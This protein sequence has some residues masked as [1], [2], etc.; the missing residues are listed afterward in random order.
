MIRM[1]ALLMMA[2]LDGFEGVLSI[3]GWFYLFSRSEISFCRYSQATATID[4]NQQAVHTWQ[5]LMIHP[6]DMIEPEWLEWYQM[7][8]LQRLE[9]S[10]RLR[11]DYLAMGGSLEPDPDP[12]SPFWSREEI[13]AFAKVHAKARERAFKLNKP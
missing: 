9:A 2:V 13:E 1:I 5:R 4:V 11:Q 6:E 3:W 7:T 8:P 10:E 12:Q